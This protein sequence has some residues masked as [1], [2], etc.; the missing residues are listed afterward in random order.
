MN[1]EFDLPPEAQ[2]EIEKIE[3]DLD[4]LDERRQQ[5]LDQIVEIVNRHEPPSS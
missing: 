4:Q 1:H 5:L 2:S 3:D